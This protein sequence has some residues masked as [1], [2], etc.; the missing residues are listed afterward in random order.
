MKEDVFEHGE[1]VRGVLDVSASMTAMMGTAHQV[2][3]AL[4]PRCAS[5]LLWMERFGDGSGQRFF[6]TTTSAPSYAITRSGETVT[7]TP[8][9]WSEPTHTMLNVLR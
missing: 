4:R 9:P 7:S 8:T 5:P 3:S 6:P 2:G 1:A